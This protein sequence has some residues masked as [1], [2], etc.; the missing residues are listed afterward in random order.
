M[1]TD[2][3]V[4]AQPRPTQSTVIPIAAVKTVRLQTP[5]AA[6]GWYWLIQYESDVSLWMGPYGSQ[7]AARREFL[8]Y[9]PTINP[10][11]KRF[12]PPTW[13]YDHPGK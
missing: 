1:S 10:R 9:A 12:T 11:V 7:S 3:L 5:E 13:Y 8:D 4:A 6:S 2:E